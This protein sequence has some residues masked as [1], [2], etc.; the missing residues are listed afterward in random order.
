[1]VDAQHPVL[2]PYPQGPAA[3]RGD[4]QPGRTVD[5]DDIEPAGDQGDVEAGH[6]AV[7]GEPL[8]SLDHPARHRA[9]RRPR[10]T[11]IR[12]YH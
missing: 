10:F 1:V 2:V 4:L 7:D 12:R 3:D 8:G 9:L 11:A 5:R 6:L